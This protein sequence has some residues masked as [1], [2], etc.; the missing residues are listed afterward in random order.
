[1]LET[2]N[3][4]NTAKR[5][6]NER[7]EVL[8]ACCVIIYF[9]I[10]LAWFAFNIHA[11]IPPDET[12]HYGR[13]M[14]YSRVLLIPENGPDTYQ[15][16]LVT[17]R[18][19]LYYWL[20]G[21]LVHLNFT[22]IDDL[23]FLRLMNGLLGVICAVY[24][25]KWTKL[26]TSN[27]LIRLLTLIIFTNILMA[28]GLFAAVSYDNLT[29]MFA[30]MSFYYLSLFILQKRAVSLA[31]FFLCLL[32]GCLSKK[33]SLPLAAM[34]AGALA[35]WWVAGMRNSKGAGRVKLL[36]SFSIPAVSVSIAAVILLVLNGLLYGGNLIRYDRIIPNAAKIIG[37]ENATQY[38]IFARGHVVSQYKTGAFTFDQAIH[39]A[40]QITN[41]SDRM[42]AIA[43]LHNARQ[44]DEIKKTFPN[45]AQFATAWFHKIFEHTVGYLGHRTLIKEKWEIYPYYWILLVL[46]FFLIRNIHWR[47]AGGTFFIFLI[48]A[49]S[50][51][52]IILWVVNYKTYI[53]T[54]RFG[55]GIAGRYLFVVLLPMCGLTAYYLVNFLSKR[56]QIVM[57]IL[58]A[59]WFIY[60]DFIYFLKVVP[61]HWLVQEW[62]I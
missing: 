37:I 7:R 57:T 48:I 28:T 35:L 62:P 58:V 61:E 36:D 45:R 16:G 12:T 22:S 13:T 30:A 10:R 33:T 42:E 27:G 24:V 44:Y 11:E 54:G 25:Y 23:V 49:I 19:Y 47:E 15:Y 26:V 59:A 2:K 52:S 40:N 32:A 46:T 55:L 4:Q 39:A 17:H 53:S 14:A 38:R 34:L 9:G 60:G 8:F 5:R 43:L 56:S 51:A 31:G 21:K 18:P 29:N 41:Y 3:P 50:Y 20:M 6:F 1:M